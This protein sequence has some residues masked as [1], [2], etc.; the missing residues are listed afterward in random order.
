[1]TERKQLLNQLEEAKKALKDYD[2]DNKYS[3]GKIYK[4]TCNVF[5]IVYVGSTVTTLKS[6]IS[7]HKNNYKRYCIG[8]DKYH[9]SFDILEN[10]DYKLEL[11][12]DFPCKTKIELLDRER[13]WCKELKSINKKLPGRTKKQYYQD[14]KESISKQKKERYTNN[15]EVQESAKK[16][17]KEWY[18][19]NKDKATEYHKQYREKHREE[20]KAYFKEYYQK[21]KHKANEYYHNNKHKLKGNE[22]INCECGGSYLRR[23]KSRHFKTKKH[24]NYA[25]L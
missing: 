5:N 18:Q 15:K 10:G 7:R 19:N 13:Y 11:I 1:M 17:T 12:E 16:R 24:Q 14:E 6:R 22:K 21:N 2:N 23:G 8:K 20:K 3:N 25:C 4:I 9:K